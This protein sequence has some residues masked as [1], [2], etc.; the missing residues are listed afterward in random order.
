MFP[1]IQKKNPVARKNKKLENIFS[2]GLAS[3][4]S[5]GAI[6]ERTQRYKVS[7][8]VE[9]VILFIHIRYLDFVQNTFELCPTNTAKIRNSKSRQKLGR[10]GVPTNG[11]N[12]RQI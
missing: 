6:V 8:S 3:E 4:A 12:S 2:A 7:E 9:R 10:H 5:G 1:S 11:L